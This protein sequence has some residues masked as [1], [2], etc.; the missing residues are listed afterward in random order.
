ML[1]WIRGKRFGWKT[2]LLVIAVALAAW[3]LVVY[4]NLR[5]FVPE[6][7]TEPAEAPWT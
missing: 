7:L 3:A 2:T 6:E 1:G 4:A 5:D